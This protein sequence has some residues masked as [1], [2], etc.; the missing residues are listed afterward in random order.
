MNT[1]KKLQP[2]P[3]RT[4]TSWNQAEHY[5]TPACYTPVATLKHFTTQIQLIIQY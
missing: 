1:L 4:P 5:S 2:P 3:H